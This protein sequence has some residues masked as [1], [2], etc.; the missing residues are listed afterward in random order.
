MIAGTFSGHRAVVFALLAALLWGG[1]D[2]AGGM[3]VKLGGG[4]V[5][6]ALRVI[7]TAHGLSLLVLLGCISW[8]HPAWPT[9]N[10]LLWGLGAGVSGALGLLL[11][12]VALANG[13]MGAS[14]AISG[15]LAAAIPAAVSSLIEG[16]PAPSRVAGFLLAAAAIY[17]IATPA[18]GSAPTQSR[19]NRQTSALAIGG[20]IGFGIY[21]VALR[22]ANSAGVLEPMTMARSASLLLCLLLLLLLPSQDWSQRRPGEGMGSASRGSQSRGVWLPPRAWL[23]AIAVAVLDTGGNLLYIESTRLGRLDAA[24]VLSSLYPASTILLAAVLLRER[25]GRQQMLGMGVALV[26]V[27]LVAR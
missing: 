18:A 23:W 19:T 13:A 3:G 20:G 22:F 10:S 21:F 24:A 6:G 7:L 12:Y 9:T 15:L 4:S 16:A 27:I 8:T 1:G 25:L 14:A 17:L 5:R 11:F 26:A 2:F